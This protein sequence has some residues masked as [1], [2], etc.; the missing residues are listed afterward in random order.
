[1]PDGQFN[2]N[3]VHNHVF[4][5]AVNGDWGEPFSLYEGEV[6]TLTWHYALSSSWVHSHVSVVAFV[7]NDDG[8]QQVT[9]A[10]LLPKT[11]E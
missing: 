9:K 2:R 3:Y 4:R 11:E 5:G 7:Y 8:V 6:Q 10:S 1:M